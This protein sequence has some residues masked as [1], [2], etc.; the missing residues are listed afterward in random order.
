VFKIILTN[1]IT[2]NWD[3][4]LMF[5]LYFYAILLTDERRDDNWLAR[6]VS[7]HAWGRSE[8]T[9]SFFVQK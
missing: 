7:T 8:A 6:D 3:F 2:L 9:A 4:S 5:F 1:N